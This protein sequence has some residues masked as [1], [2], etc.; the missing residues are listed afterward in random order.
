MKEAY[1]KLRRNPRVDI[2]IW[3]LLRDEPGPRA[4]AVGSLHAQVGAQGRPRGVRAPGRQS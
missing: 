2:F 3:F 4:L 1:A